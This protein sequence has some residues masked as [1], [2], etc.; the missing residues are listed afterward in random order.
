MDYLHEAIEHFRLLEAEQIARKDDKV[1]YKNLSW[2]DT[3]GSVSKDHGGGYVYVSSA[4]M[5]GMNLSPGDYYVIPKG[6]Y[7]ARN[8]IP[9]IEKLEAYPVKT[10]KRLA[11]AKK[12]LATL[13]KIRQVPPKKAPGGDPKIDSKI[14]REQ[15]NVDRLAGKIEKWQKELAALKA[16]LDSIPLK[17]RKAAVTVTAP[18]RRVSEKEKVIHRLSKSTDVP[19]ELWQR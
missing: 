13:E 17:H 9:R 10:E 15:E 5:H 14:A 3:I 16:E 8:L 1:L 11:R 2:K 12:R 18:K 7:R 6:E 4:G 19:K